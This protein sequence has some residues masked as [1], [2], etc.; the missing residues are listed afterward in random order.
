MFLYPGQ[1]CFECT[2]PPRQANAL[3]YLNF[4]RKASPEFQ[5][6]DNLSTF[7]GGLGQ[8]AILTRLRDPYRLGE[9]DVHPQMS[10]APKFGRLKHHRSLQNSSQ[11]QDGRFHNFSTPAVRLCPGTWFQT[12]MWNKATNSR[13]EERARRKIK[14]KVANWLHPRSTFR[15]IELTQGCRI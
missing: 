1:C 3:S 14:A 7:Q 15:S 2:I 4:I 10:V 9:G 11:K 13:K 6:T 8:I 5:L 12:L